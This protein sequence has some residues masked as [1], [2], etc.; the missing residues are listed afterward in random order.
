M[1]DEARRKFAGQ[2]EDLFVADMRELP[3]VGEFD[4]VTCI[5]D[6]VNYLLSQDE[7]VATFT[8]VAQVLAPDGIFAFDVN[9][10]KTYRTTFTQ[11]I[12][13]E[14]PGGLFCWHGE[15][16][17]VE[18]GDAA[19]ATIEAFI[20]VEDAVWRRV[21]SRHVQCHHPPGA[22]HDALADAGLECAAVAGQRP[23]CLL[24]DHVDENE[25]I[26][27]VYFARRRRTAEGVS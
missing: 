24:E 20:E 6:A 25:H 3:P 10:L 17:A 2:V 21:S 5:D 9:S 11:T 26:K 18:P 15:A 7:L 19:S 1:L 12:L 4:L 16:T 27:V 13:R 23:G 22:I 14:D 8:G